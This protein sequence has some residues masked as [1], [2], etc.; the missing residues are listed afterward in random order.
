[1]TTPTLDQMQAVNSLT[2]DE[3]RMIIY[4]LREMG[5]RR[6]EQSVDRQNPELRMEAT[7]HYELANRL[8]F[9]RRELDQSKPDFSSTK[10]THE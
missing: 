2:P 1:M 10:P 9:V 5:N 8:S 6:L 3:L 4:S 7:K